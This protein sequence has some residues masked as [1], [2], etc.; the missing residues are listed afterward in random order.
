MSGN[1]RK[2][3]RAMVHH[4]KQSRAVQSRIFMDRRIATLSQVRQ[5]PNSSYKLRGLG[6]VHLSIA[7]ARFSGPHFRFKAGLTHHVLG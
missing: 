6:P 5:A 1:H 3:G 7:L 2:S 4:A